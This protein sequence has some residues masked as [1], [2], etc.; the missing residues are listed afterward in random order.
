MKTADLIAFYQRQ[1]DE[2]SRT[3]EL[4]KG[5]LE[6]NSSVIRSLNDL[7]GQPVD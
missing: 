2:L 7:L 4:L 1:I 5:Q 3:V 6:Q